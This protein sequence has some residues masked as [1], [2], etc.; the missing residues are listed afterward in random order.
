MEADKELMTLICNATQI[1]YKILMCIAVF[2]RTDALLIHGDV[3]MNSFRVI[4]IH[5]DMACSLKSN[6]I[7]VKGRG[8]I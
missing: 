5:P 6:A 1:Y 3:T 8:G 2:E 4:G 7:P